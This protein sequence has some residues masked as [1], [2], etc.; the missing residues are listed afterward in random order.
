[1]AIWT[2]NCINKQLDCSDGILGNGMK[3][4]QRR[5]FSWEANPRCSSFGRRHG[6]LTVNRR[7]H[8]VWA[9][10]MSS[11]GGKRTLKATTSLTASGPLPTVSFSPIAGQSGR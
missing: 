4:N 9:S 2:E 5:E 10:A 11:K 3:I 8:A 1:M 6:G 7:S